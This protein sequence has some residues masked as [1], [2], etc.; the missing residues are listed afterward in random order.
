MLSVDS[1]ISEAMALGVIAILISVIPTASTGHSVT[2]FMTIVLVVYM[3]YSLHFNLLGY[4]VGI[5]FGLVSN[6]TALFSSN[7]NE[8]A[9]LP[10]VFF[11]F[12]GFVALISGVY[13]LG[14]AE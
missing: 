8:L 9:F 5:G 2:W 6:I 10:Y 13:G 1:I 7:P 11:N 14:S 12:I 4:D 3:L